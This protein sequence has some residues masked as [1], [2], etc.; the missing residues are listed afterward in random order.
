MTLHYTEGTPVSG[1]LATQ[2][3]RV[4]DRPSET[5]ADVLPTV[6]APPEAP[7]SAL[8]VPG[9]IVLDVSWSMA[10]LLDQAHSSISELATK[11]RLEPS[12]AN[13][14]YLGL[15]SFAD[16]AQC[17]LDLVR[18]ADPEVQIPRVSARG[19]GTNF[20]AAL[21]HAL[22]YLRAELPKLQAS[23]DGSTRKVMRPTIYFISD[24]ESNV[25]PDWRPVL[26]EIRT[27]RWRPIVMAFG[28]GNANRDVI[29]EIADEGMAYFAADGKAPHEVFDAILKVVLKSV[30]SQVG[31][32]QVAAQ[33]PSA[34]PPQMPIIDP[35]TDPATNALT[36]ISTI[37]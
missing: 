30:V 4:L 18:I 35:S 29:R 32:S 24:G 8:A 11:L 36:A 23:D 21:E 12:T 17:E 6:D 13:V 15:S 1:A 27:R 25:G 9:V 31:L 37:D 28:F 14:A 5:H 19:N 16:R 10:D 20:H 7:P 34:P 2:D 22:Q 26:Q 33:N 3:G